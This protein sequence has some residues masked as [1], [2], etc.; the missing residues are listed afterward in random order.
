LRYYGFA[1]E[2]LLYI[3]GIFKVFK[4]LVAS[5]LSVAVYRLEFVIFE[6][7]FIQVTLRFLLSVL[8]NCL[9]LLAIMLKT[10]PHCKT[11]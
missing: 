10:T 6:F 9:E 7:Y 11:S 1:A 8:E 3:L 5:R 4:V 2:L